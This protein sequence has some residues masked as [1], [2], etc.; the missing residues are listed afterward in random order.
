[1]LT[2]S[3]K[4]NGLPIRAEIRIPREYTDGIPVKWLSSVVV[5]QSVLPDAPVSFV[6]W[7]VFQDGARLKA[8][9]GVYDIADYG[10]ALELAYQRS[11]TRV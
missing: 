2:E 1:M 9:N 8:E 5:C 10:R 4:V 6:V 3:D 7:S 11:R